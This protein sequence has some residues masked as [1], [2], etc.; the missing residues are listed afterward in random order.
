MHSDYYGCSACP[1]ARARTRS[2]RRTGPGPASTT[3]TSTR[4]PR[5]RS[6][7]RSSRGV[8]R[9]VRPQ[10]PCQVRPLRRGLPAGPGRLRGTVAGAVRVR[11]AAP[12]GAGAGREPDGPEAGAVRGCGYSQDA[13]AASGTSRTR[14]R[15]RGPLRLACSA[16]PGARPRS[17]GADQEAEIPLGVEDAYRGGRRSDHPG[18]RGGDPRVRGRHPARRHRRAAHPAGR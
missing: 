6:A 18:Q 16:A 2:S 15:L 14:D 7:S 10:E 5:R 3:P 13:G 12:A 4:S 11:R 8:Q 1:A 17:R 9:P